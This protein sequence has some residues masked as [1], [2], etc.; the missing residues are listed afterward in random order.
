MV[1]FG[2]LGS[3]LKSRLLAASIL[4]CLAVAGPP[5]ASADEKTVV[6]VA[7]SADYMMNTP[8]MAKS[9]FEGIKAGFEK[10]HPNVT[11]ELVPIAGGFDDLNTKLSLMYNNPTAAPDVAQVAAQEAGQW[12]GSDV[13]ASLNDLV[14]TSSWWS[15][16]PDPIKKEGTIDGKV[17]AVSEGVNTTALLYD[18][19]VFKKA[20]LPDDWKP[21]NWDDILVAARAIKKSSPDVWP[22]WL[23]T[24]TAQGSEG[25]VLGGAGLMAGSSDPIF[26][27]EKDDKWVV[28]SKGLREVFN[29]YRQASAEGLLAP[30]S[31]ILNANGP[32]ILSP[33]M[34]KHQI[35]I[36]LAGNYIPQTFNKEVCGPCWDDAAKELGFA[37]IPTSHGQAPGIA[38]SFGGWD[39][40]LYKKSAHP[41]IAWQL[42]DF[43][44]QKDN[45]LVVDNNA[46]FNPPIPAFNT[47]KIFVDFAPG[48]QEKFASLVP[49]AQSPP[50]NVDYK[51]WAFAFAQA[52]EALVLKPDMSVDDAINMMKT[53]VTGQLDASKVE[54]RK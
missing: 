14:K 13:L 27:N 1:M 49:I 48:F 17:Y 23:L 7:Y 3:T 5:V 30:S 45:M 34:P 28:D 32:G 18:R 41:D 39:L 53:Y 19:T 12:A 50:A 51:V 43:M 46:G 8:E 26:Y 16:F 38:S 10:L 44:Q 25:V 35:G 31:Q 37:P 21:K 4:S 6:K 24:G 29:F 52:T 20:G 22:I 40:V 2:C 9:W 47:E 11:V 33:F 36:S 42:I 15:S 54:I